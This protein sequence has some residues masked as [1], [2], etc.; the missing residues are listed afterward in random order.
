MGFFVLSVQ[1]V[2][3]VQAVKS[4]DKQFLLLK[5]KL[6][7]LGLQQVVLRLYSCFCTL[8]LPY[9]GDDD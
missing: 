9:K 1:V 5:S 4:S 7:P 8:N 2:F 3:Q 6:M